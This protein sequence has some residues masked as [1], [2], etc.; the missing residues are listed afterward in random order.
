M[1]EDVVVVPNLNRA[2]NT[3][4]RGFHKRDR[5]GR[6]KYPGV[7]YRS[8]KEAKADGLFH[9]NYSWQQFNAAWRK[10]NRKKKLAKLSRRRNRRKAA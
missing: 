6:L 1:Q 4:R 9:P 3:R 5:F 7:A 10:N 2:A 8:F